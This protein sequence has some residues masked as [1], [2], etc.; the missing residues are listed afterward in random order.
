MP[1]QRAMDM[2]WKWTFQMIAPVALFVRN[3]AEI[4]G[5][6]LDAVASHAVIADF[7][8]AAG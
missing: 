1:G 2:I 4:E 3:W 7:R 5:S 6:V 8:S